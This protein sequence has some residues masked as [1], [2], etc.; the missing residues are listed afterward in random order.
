MTHTLRGIAAAPGIAIGPALV[1]APAAPVSAAPAGPPAEEVARLDAA[2]AAADL[3]IAAIEERLRADGKPHEAEIFGAHR[4][5]LGDPSLR[6][7]AAALIAE[8]GHAAAA[9]IAAAAEEQALELASL[10]DEYLSAR[11]ADVRDVAGQVVRALSGAQSLAERITRPSVVLAHDLGPSDLASVPRHA[12]LGFALV[13]GG[14]TA[15]TTI[16]AR[17]L[18]LPAVVGLGDEL[19]HAA[20]DGLTVAI[21]GAAGTVQISP[22]ADDLARLQGAADAIAARRAAWR[23]Q[24]DLPTVTTDGHTI[25]LVANASTPAEAEEARAWGAAGVGLLR[26]ELLFLDRPDLPGE[27]EQLSLYGAVAGA[28]PGTPIT[29]RTLDIGGD[30]F[31]PAF[32]LPKEENP[33]LGWR[34]IRIGLSRPEILLPQLRALLRAGA[35]ADI[36]IM[37]PMISTVGELRQARAL[38]EQARAELLAAGLPCAADPQL[39]VMIEV[40]AAALG[41]E[42]LARE[43]DFFSIGTNDLTQYTLAC[44]RGNTRVAELY[45]PLDPAV[46][47][48]IHMTCAAAHRHG[49]H[50]A[51]CGELGGDPRATALLIGLGVDELSCAPARLPEVR[52]AIR[53]TGLAEARALAERALACADATEV[54]GLLG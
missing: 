17:A 52:E 26:T 29:V 36:R 12:L 7:R 19:L 2:I 54:R 10:G 35:A 49:R 14:L 30:K 43:A 20:E 38:L 42:A 25:L 13:A 40:P 22:A 33:F 46:I 18:G 53:A 45:Q 6:D 31:L 28:L 34:G 1:F 11:A 8:S 9:A 51:V 47:R 21:D 23:A 15:H 24:I 3:A 5:L 39:G 50:V 4:M 27:A 41:A 48:L 16:L 32:P 37:L 44:D